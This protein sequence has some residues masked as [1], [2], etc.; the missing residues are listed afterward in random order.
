MMALV[1]ISR[2]TPS[3]NIDDH[4]IDLAGYAACGGEV[5]ERE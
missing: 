4:W 3:P 5:V 1:K 2:I